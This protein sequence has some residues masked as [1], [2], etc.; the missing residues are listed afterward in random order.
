M[1][2]S[3]I[4][5]FP[6]AAGRGAYAVVAGVLGFEMGGDV[7]ACTVTCGPGNDGTATGGG[8]T[9]G[10][11]GPVGGGLTSTGGTFTGGAAGGA[12]DE[13]GPPEPSEGTWPP[14][15]GAGL[16]APLCVCTTRRPPVGFT[17]ATRAMA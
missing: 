1:A 14:E 11:T 16:P 9:G 6:S 12:P 8:V 13:D 17:G 2:R 5:C 3:R 15:V 10:E 4:R 7:T